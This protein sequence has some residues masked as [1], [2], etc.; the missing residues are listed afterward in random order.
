LSEF[1][2]FFEK[3]NFDKWTPSNF[4]VFC[5]FLTFFSSCFFQHQAYASSLLD[6][7]AVPPAGEATDHQDVD[8]LE[9][10]DYEIIKHTI[11]LILL[12]FSMFVGKF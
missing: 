8:V 4:H 7:Y 2:E 12:C 1:I 5:L 10:D 11:L 6:S 3:I 9:S